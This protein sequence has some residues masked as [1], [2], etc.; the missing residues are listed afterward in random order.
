[1]INMT[2]TPTAGG[3][4][5]SAVVITS[6]TP[7]SPHRVILTGMGSALSVSPSALDFPDRQVGSSSPPAG[8]TLT[9][10][11]T[12]GVHIWTTAITGANGGDFGHSSACPTPPASL[13]GASSCLL[14]VTFSPGTEG[15]KVALLQISHDAGG[16]PSGVSLTGMAIA[17]APGPVSEPSSA[18]PEAAAAPTSKSSQGSPAVITVLLVAAVVP[19]AGSPQAVSFGSQAVGVSSAS[20]TVRLE[21]SGEGTLSVDRVDVSG[22]NSSDFTESNDC[23]QS[24]EPGSSCSVNL[25]FTPRSS[26]SRKARLTVH[27][28]ASAA[29]HVDLSGEGEGR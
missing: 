26:G 3:P 25:F 6:N 21:N 5:K 27:H 23:R 2:F 14:S 18:L 7:G 1:V 24:L 19:S 16:S 29:L 12:E 13:A 4:R 20:Y 17:P 22:T 15:A 28:G 10:L 11:G 8:V 9:N